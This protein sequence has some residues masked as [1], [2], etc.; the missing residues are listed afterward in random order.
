[1]VQV[2][3]QSCT[4]VR[5]G[6]RGRR[7][8]ASGGSNATFPHFCCIRAGRKRQVLPLAGGKGACESV[9]RPGERPSRPCRP[10]GAVTPWRVSP[11][12]G[13]PRESVG[14][15]SR[16]SPHAHGRDPGRRAPRLRQERRSPAPCPE[17]RP[18]RERRASGAPGRPPTRTGRDGRGRR[19]D[20]QGEPRAR[21]EQGRGTQREPRGPQ[22]RPPRLPIPGGQARDTPGTG[23]DGHTSAAPPCPARLSRYCPETDRDRRL[24]AWT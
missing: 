20:G 14:R 18:P 15:P 10:A 21:E 6:S 3:T 19:L 7:S 12:R 11:A 23:A 22:E 8:R 16:A 17:T 4:L 5:R 9:R 2:Y 13:G 1:M 24:S